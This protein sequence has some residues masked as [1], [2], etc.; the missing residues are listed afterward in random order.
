MGSRV[1]PPLAITFMHAIESLIL[2]SPGDQPALYLRYVD[3]IF[4]VWTHGV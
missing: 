1:A 2:S 4:G 3:D